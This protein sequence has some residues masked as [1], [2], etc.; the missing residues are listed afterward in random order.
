MRGGSPDS[1]C[2]L[3]REYSLSVTLNICIT[4]CWPDNAYQRAYSHKPMSLIPRFLAKINVCRRL[5]WLRGTYFYVSA[6]SSESCRGKRMLFDMCR[7]MK[8]SSHCAASDLILFVFV[9]HQFVFDC[10]VSHFRRLR[11]HKM[12]G[13]YARYQDHQPFSFPCSLIKHSQTSVFA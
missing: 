7:T 8:F 6:Q 11:K 4:A 12:I 10:S 2:L 9:K 3:M 5:D 13:M 1:S